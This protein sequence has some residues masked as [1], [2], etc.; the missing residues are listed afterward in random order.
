M[1]DIDRDA[2][3]RWVELEIE[4]RRQSA[5]I[6]TRVVAEWQATAFEPITYDEWIK[7]GKPNESH[8]RAVPGVF[9]GRPDLY[10]PPNV[11]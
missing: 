3:D 8:I 10:E 4:R 1:P 6:L 11:M 5:S 9:G 7:A 2:Y